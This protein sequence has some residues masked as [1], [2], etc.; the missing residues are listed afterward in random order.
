MLMVRANLIRLLPFLVL[1]VAAQNTF[2]DTKICAE[3][4]SEIA[5]AYSRTGMGRSFSR[6]GPQNISDGVSFDHQLSGTR[7][8]MLLRD[9]KYYQR[10]WRIDASG[11]EADVQESAIDYVMGS[12]NHARTYLHR[13]TRGVLIQLPLAWYP[14][15]GGI[16]AMNPGYDREYVL[17]PNAITYECMACHNSFPK[18]PADHE[19][20]GS[21]PVYEGS[22]PEGIDCQR[23]HGPG[24]N[25]VKAAKKGLPNAQAIV[26]PKRL[27]AARQMDVC[28]QCHLETTSLPLPHS[29]RKYDRGP[30]SYRP[31]EPLSNFMSVFDHAPD[32]EHRNDFEIVSSAYRLRQSLCFLKSDERLTCTTCHDPHGRIQEADHYNDACRT[33]HTRVDRD[34]AVHV[35]G[36]DC[37]SCHMPK[38]RTQDVVHA[39]MTDHLI[40]RRPPPAGFLAP[41]SERTD[42]ASYRGEVVPYFANQS[43]LYRAVAQ[44][45]QKSNLAKGLPRLAAEIASQKPQQPA[46]YI[47][48]GQA[49]L[50]SGKPAQAIAP[51]EEAVR[52]EPASPVALLNLGDALTQAG[53]HARA[54]SLLS[55]AVKQN[56]TDALLWYQLGIAQSNA[57]DTQQAIATFKKA[58]VLDPDMVEA[59][60]ILGAALASAG[61]LE[62]GAKELNYALQ[63]SPDYP[64]ALGNMGHLLA[65]RGELAASQYYFARSIRLKPNDAETRTNYAVALAGLNDWEG[66]QLQADAAVKLDPKSPEAHNF[67]GSLLDRSGH[68]ADALAE[69]LQ[70]TRLL[71]DFYLAHWNAALIYSRQG[72]VPSAERHLREAA[73]SPDPNLGN[74]ASQALLQLGSH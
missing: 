51:F 62:N 74:K 2:V 39:V 58:T 48:L 9:G 44:V 23:C 32:T 65:A 7:Y 38:R 40:A 29:I 13:T 56:P 68:T 19:E 24:A 57:G 50:A 47:E 63:L 12:G 5:K 72:N 3:C 54:I 20:P 10:R 25:H 71:P 52:R 37:V 31:G 45:T 14:E 27:S 60:N 73:K 21:E 4:H 43:K 70:A 17:A 1:P 61:D 15:Q 26:N 49:W 16:W 46:F 59:H 42:A 67:R 6:P 66:A 8:A 35:A 64:D 28:M 55:R 33:C 30:F 11:A 22:L 18:I 36:S 41:L 53:N 69:F 34:A